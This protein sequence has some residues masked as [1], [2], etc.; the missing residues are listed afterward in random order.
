MHPG[1]ANVSRQELQEKLG[2][3]QCLNKSL[4]YLSHLRFSVDFE[5]D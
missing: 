2:Q 1:R 4:S 5:S 3:V